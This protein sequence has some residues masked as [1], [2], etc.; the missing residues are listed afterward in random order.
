MLGLTE[1]FL[2]NFVTGPCVNVL[3]VLREVSAEFLP[4]VAAPPASNTPLG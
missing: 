3:G 2:H 1:R 4:A